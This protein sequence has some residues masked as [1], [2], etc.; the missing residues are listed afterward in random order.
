MPSAVF[1]NMPQGVHGLRVTA[2]GGRQPRGIIT[3]CGSTKFRE[4]FEAEQARLSLE[5]NIVISVG[6][7]GH[8]LNM[9]CKECRRPKD[10][11]LHDKALDGWHDF[12]TTFDF[13]TDEEP[14][15]LKFMLDHLHFRKIDLADEIHV[16]NKD[17]YVGTSTAR[18]VFY[19]IE[20]GV[21]IS[22]MEPM[23]AGEQEAVFAK[24]EAAWQTMQRQQ[25]AA[26]AGV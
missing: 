13:G 23:T 26:M 20:H 25:A 21:G 3:L 19:A 9:E 15:P 1:P 11:V 5:G 12:V 7:F 6:L 4:E 18:E 17:H 14:S 16:I 24:G 8:A 2:W 22:W 10:H